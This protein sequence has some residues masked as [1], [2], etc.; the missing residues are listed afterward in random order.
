MYAIYRVC[1][2]NKYVQLVSEKSVFDEIKSAFADNNN[3]YIYKGEL[4]RDSDDGWCLSKSAQKVLL[5]LNDFH[6]G[7]EI[8]EDIPSFQVKIF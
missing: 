3:F 8:P 2:N 7:S 5:D 6:G 1:E 4:F